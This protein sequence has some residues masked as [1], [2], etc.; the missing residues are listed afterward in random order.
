MGK[1]IS[2]RYQLL[3]WHLEGKK[4]ELNKKAFERD[5]GLTKWKTNSNKNKTN[6][7]NNISNMEGNSNNRNEQRRDT[8][9]PRRHSLGNY[10]HCR[11][12]NQS[13]HYNVLKKYYHK[14]YPPH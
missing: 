2:K 14:H 10:N 6:E 11:S 7:K 3:I 1:R 13:N 12:W 9:N 4:I 8:P 5:T